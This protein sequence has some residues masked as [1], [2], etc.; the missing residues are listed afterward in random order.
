M[1]K[2]YSHMGWAWFSFAELNYNCSYQMYL[3]CWV[4]QWVL[5]CPR[6]HWAS[7]HPRPRETPWD[8]GAAWAKHQ[9]VRSP[10]W[11]K[12]CGE[13]Q[14]RPL[15]YEADTG[16]IKWDRASR[17]P[18]LSPAMLGAWNLACLVDASLKKNKKQNNLDTWLV[19]VVSENDAKSI[20]IMLCNH[21]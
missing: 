16:W 13:G 17:P 8:R 15:G 6:V 7:G 1:L 19:W 21:L 4:W 3:R 20:I 10:P 9:S 14:K 11:F 12:G 18:D 2:H 5:W